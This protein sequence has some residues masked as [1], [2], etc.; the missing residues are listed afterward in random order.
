MRGI[1]LLHPAMQA[2][3]TEFLAECKK[4]GLPVQITDTWRTV[5][6]QDALYAQGRTKPGS[7]VT[8]CK[9][10]DYQSPHMWGFAFDVCRNDKDSPYY[11]DKGKTANGFGDGDSMFTKFGLAGEAVG[12]CWGGR[13]TSYPGGDKPHFELDT[14]L[15]SHSTA[16]LKKQYVTPE[17]FKATWGTSGSSPA[18]TV[19]IPP[20][21]KRNSK[22][23]TV[24]KL[25]TMLNTVFKLDT[26]V[27]QLVVD[28]D[29][30]I[31]TE[32]AVMYFQLK[33]NLAPDGSCGPLTWKKLLGV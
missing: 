11:N 31:K 12:L 3:V 28:G 33:N 13:F 32:G 20:T 21:V 9:G 8:N 25:Q 7:I 23:D 4:R 22:G 17:K 14:Y 29:F 24:K 30:G 27:V 5:A 26:K 15:P 6:E 19:T 18:A 2:K 1:E 16:T 10:S